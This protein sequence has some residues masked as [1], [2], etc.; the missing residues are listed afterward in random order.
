MLQPR[1]QAFAKNME[2]KLRKHK[3]FVPSDATIAQ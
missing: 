3:E 2:K 1:K